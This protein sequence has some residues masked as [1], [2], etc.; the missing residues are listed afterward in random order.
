MK[1]VYLRHFFFEKK[2]DQIE[3]KKYKNK[4]NNL[5]KESDHLNN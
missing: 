4:L 5:N 3:A 1:I 2:N